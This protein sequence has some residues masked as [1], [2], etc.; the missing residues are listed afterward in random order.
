MA[1]A[2]PRETAVSRGRGQDLVPTGWPWPALRM[3]LG[4]S[5]S[6]TEERAPRTV[7][8]QGGTCDVQGGGAGGRDSSSGD[9]WSEWGR[10]AERAWDSPSL[11]ELVEEHVPLP[12]R[13]EVKRILGEAVVDLNL[14][15]RAEVAM[16]QAL[17]Q[18]ARSSR[19]PGS[20]PISDPSSLLA[21]PPLLRDLV[22]QELRQLLQSL[23]HKAISEGRDQAQAWAQYSPKVLRFALEEPTCDLPEQEQF[24]GRAVEPSSQRTLSVIKD[25]LN[26]SGIDQVAG[27][28]R[29][30]AVEIVVGC[31]QEH[32]EDT[33]NRA[34]LLNVGFLEALKEDAAY[35]C[36][37]F[38]DVDLVPMDDR[39]LYRCG[40]QPR[41]FAIAMD[42]FGFR[43]PYAGYFGGVSGLSK[44]Q[45]LRINGF[46]NEYWGWGG[47]DDD[48]FNRI[49]LTGMKISRPDIRIGRYRMIKHDR[50]KHNEPN[51][52]R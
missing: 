2:V 46:P 38:S 40:D 8:E 45:F 27:H 35:D 3:A 49:S 39:N 16:L 37:I 43:L 25:Q 15:L 12:E 23:R 18:E 6:R 42:K 10:A 21:P 50:D 30:A 31:C 26:V 44:T 32:G 48:I 1:C 5:R 9:R 7:T 29:A 24:Q 20:H 11:W 47:E 41:H 36:F 28:L 4:P 52:Q 19:A 51:P 22:R 13:P 33:F 17:L 14:E 34:K